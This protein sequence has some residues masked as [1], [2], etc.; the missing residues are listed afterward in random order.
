[1][2]IWAGTGTSMPS[3]VLHIRNTHVERH[4]VYSR[5]YRTKPTIELPASRSRPAAALHAA[6]GPTRPSTRLML[7][8]HHLHLYCS[9]MRRCNLDRLKWDPRQQQ[10]GC[11]LAAVA[12]LDVR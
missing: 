1:M 3:A 7:I 6:G 8:T 2:E 12:I 5:S 11:P 10:S 4:D 9:F